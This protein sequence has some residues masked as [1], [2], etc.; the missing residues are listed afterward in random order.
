MREKLEEFLRTNEVP[1]EV[2]HH[3]RV[4]TAQEVAAV[5]HVPGRMLAKVVIVKA[6][7][8]MLMTVVP[9]PRRVHLDKVKDA[10]GA[11]DVRLATED[12][13]DPLFPDCETG[14][15]PPFGN[16]YD[17]DVYVDSSLADQEHIMFEA[18]T[19][20]DTMRMNYADFERLVGPKTVD[21]AE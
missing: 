10:V 20:T 3:P 16:L 15:M 1:F 19:H 2:H 8:R 6:D 17:V 11:N 9:A 5:E 14:T 13:F 12:E 7:D 21:I 4:F 18:G